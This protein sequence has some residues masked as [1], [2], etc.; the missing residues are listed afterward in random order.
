MP[1]RP[2]FFINGKFTAQRVTGVQR[3]GRELVRA[4]DAVVG[5]SALA[6]ARW[7]LLCPPGAQRPDLRH[8]EL[9][10]CGPAGLPLHLWEQALLPWVARSGCLL[11]LAGTGPFW[12]VRQAVLQHDAAVFDHPQAYRRAFVGWYRRLFA[13][14]ARSA[15]P[16]FVV[17][18]F[19]RGRLAR[20]LG[21]D[22]ARWQLLHPGADH[23]STVAADGALPDRLGLGGRPFFLAVGSANP[24]KNLPALVRAYGALRAM[25]G[26][27]T[28]ALVM[29]GGSHRAVFAAEAGG[30][31]PPDLHRLG[32]VDDATLKALYQRALGLVFP[33]LY[34]G[35]GLPPLEAMAEGCPVVVARAASLEEV[36]GEAALYVDPQSPASMA[37]GMQRLA[38]DAALRAALRAAGRERAARFTWAAAARCVHDALLA[39]VPASR[40]G[41]GVA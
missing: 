41:E 20:H 33:S 38:T 40:L 39:D 37:S 26:P 21:V 12:A 17:S 5:E 7:V 3:V 9:R 31:D 36:C 28:P 4:L 34:E 13:R 14:Q 19:S 15:R 10:T 22:P 27:N 29:V 6:A 16:L 30:E 24:T 8:V 2:T 23:L 32:S 18:D 11:N 1:S 25:S 35:F